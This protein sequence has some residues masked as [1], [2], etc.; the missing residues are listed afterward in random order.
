[1]KIQ[2]LLDHEITLARELFAL[3]QQDSRIGFEDNNYYYVPIDFVE[4]VIN[5]EYIGWKFGE[6]N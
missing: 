3:T 2:Q 5:C 6:Q 1:M 4:K